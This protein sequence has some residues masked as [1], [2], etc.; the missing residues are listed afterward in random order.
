MKKQPEQTAHTKQTIIDAF[1]SLA[2]AKGIDKVTVSA[3]AKKAELNRGTFYVYFADIEDLLAQTEEHLIHDIQQKLKMAITKND[4]INYEIAIN[5]MVE[6]FTLYDDKFFLLLGK[7]GD[8]NFLDR[9]RE[10]AAAVFCQ[11]LN[12]ANEN[13]YYKYFIAYSTSALTGLITYW[14]DSGREIS[15]EELANILYKV[16]TKG[17]AGIVFEENKI[18]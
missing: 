4:N 8:P 10:E 11:I 17:I 13:I 6:V 18:T 3:I 1:W 2:N 14:H 15:A 12:P 5:K 16:V 9:I 7:H